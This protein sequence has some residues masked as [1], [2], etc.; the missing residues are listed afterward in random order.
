MNDVSAGRHEEL[1]GKPVAQVDTPV[2]LLDLDLFERNASYISKFLA[3][4]DLAWRPHTKAHKSPYLA[5]LQLELGAIGITCAKL[6]EA[7]VMVASGIPEVLVANHLG[8]RR[9][10]ER[11]AAIQRDA[12]VILCVDDTEHVRLA[13]VAAV[14]AGVTIPLLIEVDIGMCRVGVRSTDAALDLAAHID[15]SPGVR[16][17]GLMG[18]EGHLLTVWPKVEKRIRCAEALAI[19]T[20]TAESLR[21]NGHAVEIVSSGGTG[22]FESTDGIPGLTESQAGGGCLMDR[23]YAEDCHVGLAHALTL[24]ATTVSVQAEGRAIVDAG[25]K[26]LGSS[27]GFSPPWVL[28]RPGVE[29]LALSAEHGILTVGSDRLRVGDQVRIVPAYSDAMLFLHDRLVGHRR[30]RITDIISMPGRGRLA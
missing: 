8:T 24:L 17:A 30:G 10:W 3:E 4:H 29:V 21:A 16:L 5:H 27:S 18:Y 25:F 26:S 11:A 6:G 22:S 14:D 23:F 13:S 19:L 28:D 1:I 9:K 15:A 7:E 2:P 12:R 20:A